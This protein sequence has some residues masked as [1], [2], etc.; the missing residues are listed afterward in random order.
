MNELIFKQTDCR[1]SR[2]IL[3][4]PELIGCWQPKVWDEEHQKVN[5]KNFASRSIV[6]EDERFKFALGPAK[7]KQISCKEIDREH[8]NNQFFKIRAQ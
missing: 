8:S 4:L 7:I 6:N 5:Y 1:K 2:K 3:T